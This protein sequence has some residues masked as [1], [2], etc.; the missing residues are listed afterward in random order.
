MSTGTVV[1]L[2]VDL[3]Q[4]E[5]NYTVNTLLQMG[6]R[7]ESGRGLSSD[8]YMSRS[9]ENIE[10]GFRAWVTEGTLLGVTG[11]HLRRDTL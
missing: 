9:H 3:I 10:K 8:G 1:K 6:Y 11:I 5:T 7:I 2:N 4:K